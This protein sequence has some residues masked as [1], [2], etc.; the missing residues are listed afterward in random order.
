MI[1]AISFHAVQRLQERRNCE[2]LL[3]HLN[4]IQKWDLPRTGETIH[5]GFRYITRDG[6]LVTVIPDRKAIKQHMA[7]VAMGK[8]ER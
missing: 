1:S 8:E 7:D 5:K 4:K 3:R 6:V 2:H